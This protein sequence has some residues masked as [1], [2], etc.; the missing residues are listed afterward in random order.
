MRMAH[1]P[2]NIVITAEYNRITVKY[3]ERGTRFA[4]IR[5]AGHIFQ[6]LFLQAEALRLK[7]SIC[8]RIP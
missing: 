1:A 7:A 4:M 6:N 3:R 5:E 2:L 8:R